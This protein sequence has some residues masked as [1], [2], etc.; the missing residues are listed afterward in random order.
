M[1]GPYAVGRAGVESAGGQTHAANAVMVVGDIRVMSHQKIK[2]GQRIFYLPAK[3]MA[4][5]THSLGTQSEVHS[6]SGVRAERDE[7]GSSRTKQ[8]PERRIRASRDGTGPCGTN[9]GSSDES[10]PLR[11]N[12]VMRDESGPVRPTRVPQDESWPAGRTRVPRD[13]SGP[14]G[15]ERDPAR[16]TK[17]RK[18]NQGSSK[19][20]RSCGPWDQPELRKTN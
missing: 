12:Q 20:I 17:A 7:S 4:G 19:R 1:K 9:Q 18:M 13:E 2:R 11:M 3:A 5:P 8:G 15:T 10:G 14:H 16:R 6:L